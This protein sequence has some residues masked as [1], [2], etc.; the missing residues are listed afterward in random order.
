MHELIEDFLWKGKTWRIAKKTLT[1]QTEH[2]GVEIRE[3]QNKMESKTIMLIMK[4][5]IYERLQN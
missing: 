5:Y 2:S 3:I 1:L 4:V